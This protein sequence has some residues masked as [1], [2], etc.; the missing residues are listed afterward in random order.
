M[1]G[2]ESQ[3]FGAFSWGGIETPVF[4]EVYSMEMCLD[5]ISTPVRLD[6][7][8]KQLSSFQCCSVQSWAH[9]SSRSISEL[10][11][12]SSSALIDHLSN[13]SL[14]KSA[15]FVLNSFNLMAFSCAVPY[16]LGMVAEIAQFFVQLFCWFALLFLFVFRMC[17]FSAFLSKVAP[18]SIWLRGGRNTNQN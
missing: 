7:L 9:P 13:D 3:S 1:P 2:L 5:G 11:V 14:I 4:S 16:V 12:L 6:V 17:F 15:T 8:R 18:R 10:N